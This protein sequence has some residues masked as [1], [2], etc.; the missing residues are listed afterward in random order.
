MLNTRSNWK[1]I[2]PFEGQVIIIGKVEL[3]AVVMKDK[4]ILHSAVYTGK[5]Q[6]IFCCFCQLDWGY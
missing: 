6:K 4:N 3:Q 2:V 1:I 5:L